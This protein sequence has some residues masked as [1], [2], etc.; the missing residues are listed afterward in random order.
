MKRV[1][2]TGATGFVGL[3]TA[4][5]LLDAGCEVIC[6]LRPGTLDKLEGIA[7]KTIE[8]D[9]I[10]AQSSDWWA[11]AC[12][13]IDTVIHLAWYAEPGKYLTSEKNLDCLAG[14]LALA[15]G[16]TQA[17]VRRFVGVGTCFEYDLTD[18][19]LSVGNTAIAPLTPY[20]G[21]K[22]AANTML[23]S[24]FQQQGTSYMWARLFYLYG[25][26]EDPRRLVPYLHAQMQAGNRADLTSGTAIKDY[27]DVED[28]AQLLVKDALGET[29][30]ASNI[31]S[32]QGITI[33]ELA[34]QIAD[35]Y[36]RRDLLNFGARPDNLTDPPIVIGLRNEVTND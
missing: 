22:A 2:L 5:A 1:L 17:G 15:K 4:R 13:D 23:H 35:Q 34:E 27:M 26:R 18:G 36:D 24:W 32:G 10:F 16:A 21:A 19:Y 30:G 7:V 11:D 29:E 20:A 33:R 12:Q 14:T 8:C 6:T 9:D 31:C 28:A 3:P 25:A